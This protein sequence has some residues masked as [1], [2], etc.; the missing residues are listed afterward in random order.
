MLAETYYAKFNSPGALPEMHIEALWL[1]M[2]N[3]KI[4][5]RSYYN[6]DELRAASFCLFPVPEATPPAPDADE[7][8]FRKHDALQ[9]EARLDVA[10]KEALAR[11]FAL[12]LI[13]IEGT[14]RD[15]ARDEFSKLCVDVHRFADGES[16]VHGGIPETLPAQNPGSWPPAVYD[17]VTG[18]ARPGVT[19]G[20]V[21]TSR[22]WLVARL[23]GV[24]PERHIP[25]SA[26]TEMVRELVFAGNVIPDDR[27]IAG[28]EQAIDHE[29][30]YYRR[31]LFSQWI[32][33]IL[34]QHAVTA[35][36]N[37]LRPGD[38]LLAGNAPPDLEDPAQPTPPSSEN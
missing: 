38:E 34:A 13:A 30:R 17:L 2:P 31:H 26:A 8:T 37:R 29:L 1:K 18:M 4:A 24:L 15:V 21:L 11:H 6:H 23:D 16:V 28:G 3:T 9:E 25:Y 36:H 32:Q 10:A 5:L 27:A 33:P 12:L 22:G 20:P 14:G 7:E 19:A 35:F